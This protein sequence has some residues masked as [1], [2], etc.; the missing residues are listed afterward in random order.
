MNSQTRTPQNGLCIYSERTKM[1]FDL[2]RA[3]VTAAASAR[4]RA[5]PP[6]LSVGLG[7]LAGVRA[8]P[9]F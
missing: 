8:A 7:Q 5:S 3:I 2:R 4:P 1:L 6:D 9:P